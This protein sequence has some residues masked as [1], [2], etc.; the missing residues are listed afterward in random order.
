MSSFYSMREGVLVHPAR[1]QY[2]SSQ[3]AWFAKPLN[4]ETIKV[5]FR[6]NVIRYVFCAQKKN[7]QLFSR[8]FSSRKRFFLYLRN[9]NALRR[10]VRVA[11]RSQ[12][13]TIRRACPMQVASLVPQLV[14]RGPRAHWSFTLRAVAR[15]EF[16]SRPTNVHDHLHKGLVGTPR[17][18]TRRIHSIVCYRG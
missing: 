11:V 8:V 13:F 3:V 15:K 7:S 16:Q 18:A 4:N 6:E 1:R 17:P 9:D 5:S 14:L 12:P 2:L 10:F